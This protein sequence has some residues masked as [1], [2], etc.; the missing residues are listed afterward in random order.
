MTDDQL[1]DELRFLAETYRQKRQ[2]N[3]R[4]VADTLE[5]LAEEY[6]GDGGA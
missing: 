2:C 1:L 3:P 6:G 4:T 5:R